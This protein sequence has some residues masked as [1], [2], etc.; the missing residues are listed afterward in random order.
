M[1]SSKSGAVRPTHKGGKT[2]ELDRISKTV[3]ELGLQGRL[4]IRPRERLRSIVMSMFVCVSV[5]LSAKISQEPH[6]RSLPF[7]CVLP[8]S[9]SWS[10]SGTLT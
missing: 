5:C 1:G 3:Q 9:V 8:M 7:L 10:S 2:C 6:V 4:I